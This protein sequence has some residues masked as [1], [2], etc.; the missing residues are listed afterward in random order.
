MEND[1]VTLISKD[2]RKK[3]VC[4]KYMEECYR[5]EGYISSKNIHISLLYKLVN[6]K[7]FRII[8]IF[9]TL[10]FRCKFFFKNPGHS[11]FIIFDKE[12]SSDIEE[13]LPNKNYI[14][15]ST[16][17]DDIK[18][19][20]ISKKIV[21]HIIKNIFKFS[22]KKNYLTALI[23]SI[24]PKIILTHIS[25]SEDFHTISKI[26]HREIK[27]IAIQTYSPGYFDHMFS[28]KRKKSFFIPKLFC[29]SKYDEL[30]YKK[31]DVNIES[32]ESIGS[33]KS[34]LCNEYINSEK[35]KINPNKYD[36]CLIA[37]AHENLNGDLPHVKNMA[38]SVGLTAEFTYKLCKKY[39]LNIVFSGRG[40][41]NKEG[42]SREIHFYKHYLKNY[43][44]EI[45]QS[46]ND[47]QSRYI[48]SYSNMM[49]SKLVIAVFSTCLREA[50]S[51]E[52]KNII[53]QYYRTSR[54]SI[55][56]TRYRISTRKYMHFKKTFL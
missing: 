2:G 33:L 46:S 29:F 43:D 4:Y 5:K 17:I 8:K 25:D 53:I 11:Q 12:N 1:V 35:I 34:S 15:L 38:D 13:V 55:P 49:Q 56:R 16:R 3:I 42:A 24:A 51:F 37:E 50:I 9:F 52:K 45:S 44:F 6:F 18:E 47:L 36:I 32:F 39:N 54:Y 41:K 48:N 31:K 30:F 20:Y 27:F 22:L 28:E 10:C 19:I 23:K 26:L 40:I 14:I 21:I 7:I